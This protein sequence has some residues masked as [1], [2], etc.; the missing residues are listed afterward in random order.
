M[1]RAGHLPGHFSVSLKAG[2]PFCTN[3]EIE[4]LV[5]WG[6]TRAWGWKGSGL[7]C[8]TRPFLVLE[9][10]MVNGARAGQGPASDS[11]PALCWHFPPLAPPAPHWP[12]PLRA[13]FVVA[14][15]LPR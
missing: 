11:S 13:E 7:S 3:Q 14:K 12:L 4:S 5:L 1:E 15:G 10:K 2:F 8:P 9:T 6:L